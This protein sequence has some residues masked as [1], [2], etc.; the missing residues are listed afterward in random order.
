MKAVIEKDRPSRTLTQEKDRKFYLLLQQW[1]QLYIEQGLLFRRYEDCHGKE[2]WAQ[3]VVPLALQKEIL[4]DVH[5]GAVGGHLREDKTLNRLRERFYW[6]GHTEDVHKWCQQ[7]AECAMRKTPVPKQRAKL[8][9][10][11]PSYPLQLV[12]MDLLGP[13]PESSQKNSKSTPLPYNKVHS[14]ARN[15]LFCLKKPQIVYKMPTLLVEM[16][17]VC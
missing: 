7:C 6:P 4:S 13:L 10:I 2:K 5:S 1:D 17:Q 15:P 9:N 11:L 12:A 3:W 14:F 16:P 8:T